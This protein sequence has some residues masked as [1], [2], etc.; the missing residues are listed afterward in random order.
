[1]RNTQRKDVSLAADASDEKLKATTDAVTWI[2]A[3]HSKPEHYFLSSVV[4]TNSFVR[5][6]FIPYHSLPH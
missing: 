1:M 5:M 3:S 4:V 2:L 6:A